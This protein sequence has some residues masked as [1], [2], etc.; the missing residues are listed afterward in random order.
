M[1]R[2]AIEW[3]AGSTSISTPFDLPEIISHADAA[4]VLVALGYKPGNDDVDY[5]LR[6]EVEI[7]V[8]SSGSLARRS[9]HVHWVP[10]PVTSV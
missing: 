6:P 7:S 8:V 9:V 3:S 2:I 4:V 1:P 10:D 5:G